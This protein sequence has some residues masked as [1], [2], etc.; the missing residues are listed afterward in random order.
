M[1]ITTGKINM[2]MFFKLPL[3]WWS[4]MR[5]L[6]LTNTT[7]VVNIKYKW[8]NQNPFKS[9]FWA[10]QGMAAE[11]STGVL[12]MQEIEK[13]NRKVS[14]LVTH[15]EG[16]FFKKAKGKIVFTCSGGNQIREAIEKS[17]KTGEGEVVDL[18]SEG[19]NEDGV[20]VSNFKFQ[21]SLKVK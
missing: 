20:V 8:M 12:V 6:S 9:M 19:I 1:K 21:W 4:G 17:I 10:A 18:I 16:D 11:M 3:G 7:A 14:M 15:Q 2:F 13:S 5:V